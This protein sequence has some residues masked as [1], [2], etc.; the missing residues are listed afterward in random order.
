[1]AAPPDARAGQVA[2]P[3]RELVPKPAADDPVDYYYRLP[4][5]RIYRARL[6]L[7]GRLLGSE[8]YDSLLEVGYGS[9][10]FLPELARRTSRL[11]GI[12]VHGASEQVNEMLARLGLEADLREASL[13]DLPFE[14]GTFDALVCLSVLEHIVELEAALSEFRRVLKTGGVAVVGF[15]VRSPVTDT[16]FRVVGYNPREIHPSSH[17]DILGAA[18]RHP[19]FVLEREEHY[20]R[21]APVDVA[22]YAGARCRAA[23]V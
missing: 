2:L 4:T 20:P 17:R 18:R 15:P 3:P 10:I 22:G 14:D 8:S 5:A 13:F 23:E 7:A 9:G 21:W 1:M 19:G 11:A 12:D 6:R 16:F